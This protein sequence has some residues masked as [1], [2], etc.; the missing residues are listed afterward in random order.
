MFINSFYCIFWGFYKSLSNYRK[1]ILENVKLKQ[2]HML[3]AIELPPW[4]W[5]LLT[6]NQNWRVKEGE[7]VYF[8]NIV[9]KQ[10]IIFC[11]TRRTFQQKEGEEEE[12]DKETY[13]S[14]GRYELRH[15]DPKRAL[16]YLDK[17]TEGFGRNAY[18]YTLRSEANCI[19]GHFE[20]KGFNMLLR[21]SWFQKAG[22]KNNTFSQCSCQNANKNW[23]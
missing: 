18:L 8:L 3:I 14:Q 6:S 19:L 17:A 9:N 2:L 22:R 23:I 10:L 13:L 1:S 11:K 20:G 21:L 12:C 15:G 4:I 16:Y 5:A 7:F